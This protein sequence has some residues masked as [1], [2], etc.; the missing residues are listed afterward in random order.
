MQ[1]SLAMV[2]VKGGL[3]GVF[4][5]LAGWRSIAAFWRSVNVQRGSAEILR[6]LF[7][8]HRRCDDLQNDNFSAN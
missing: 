4:N 3:E 1:L 6:S 2:V 8:N 7:G 5:Q